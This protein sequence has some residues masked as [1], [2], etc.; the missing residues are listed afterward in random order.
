MRPEYRAVTLRQILTHRAGL[1]PWTSAE[2]F[3]R[4]LTFNTT[5][6]ASGRLAFA[7]AVLS[8]PPVNVP[9]TET[10]Y[11]YFVSVLSSAARA[12]VEK[13]LAMKFLRRSAP[14]GR[15]KLARRRQPRESGAKS[16]Q[17][18]VGAAGD[19]RGVVSC[20]P[21]GAPGTGGAGSRALR[22]GLISVAP[23]GLEPARGN[24]TK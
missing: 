21:C 19:R 8:E 17:S 15:Q 9:G 12:Y 3:Q 24:L 2:V 10:R 20:R 22:P 23:A 18:P 7:T 5:D 4:A 1:P 14:Q 6:L 11:F 13:E 16:T